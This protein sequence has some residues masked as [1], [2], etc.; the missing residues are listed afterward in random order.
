MTIT[1]KKVSVIVPCYNEESTI[2]LLLDAILKQDFPTENIEVIIADALSQDK[3]REKIKEFANDHSSL[4]I[5]VV[6]NPQRTIPAAVN[7]AAAAANGEY[8]V[9]LDAHSM[10]YPNYISTCIHDLENGK[11]ENVGGAWEIKPGADT[12]IARAIAAAAAHPLGVGDARY[13]YSDQTGEVDTVPFGSFRRD[14]F[15]RIGGFDESLLTN[16]DYEFN[17]RIRKAGGKIWFDPTIRCIYFARKNLKE[18]AKQYWRYGFW[19]LQMLKRYPKTIRWRQA[20]PPL[21]VLANI[22]GIILSLFNASA[23]QSYFIL[24]GIYLLILLAASI[25]EAM[26]KKEP[27]LVVGIPAAIITMHFSW[28]LGFLISA[29]TRQ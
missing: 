6:E 14:L 10:P 21:F 23:A 24:L 7:A 13:R 20:L 12:S 22:I 16:E 27:A 25:R 3:T 17:V 18:L 9:R 1:N 29:I 2:Q 15:F 11:G 5:K 26:K 8:L 4:K 19:K 28:G